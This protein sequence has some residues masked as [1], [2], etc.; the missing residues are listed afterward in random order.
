MRQGRRLGGGSTTRD[1]RT[2]RGKAG[3]TSE[4]EGGQGGS[5]GKDHWPRLDCPLKSSRTWNHLERQGRLEAGSVDEKA[6]ACGGEH[7]HRRVRRGFGSGDEGGNWGQ[8]W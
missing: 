8:D 3:V 7:R 6:C 5:A 1:S 2:A 4:G